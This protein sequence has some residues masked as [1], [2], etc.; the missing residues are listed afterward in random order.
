MSRLIATSA[1]LVFAALPAAA[2]TFI[3][4]AEFLAALDA[5]HFATIEAAEELALSRAVLDDAS[6]LEN[7][8]LEA[9]RE[10]PS[11]PVSQT[12]LMLSWRLPD[13]ARGREIEAATQRL[14]SARARYAQ[15]L[16][17]LRVE[18]RQVYAEWALASAREERLEAQLGR[19]ADLARRERARAEEGESSGLEA[20]RLA[21]AVDVLS[22]R[23]AIA[24]AEREA[25]QARARVWN[26]ATPADATPLLPELPAAPPAESAHPLLS[27]AQ[28]E[29]DAALA[30]REA[31]ARFL[32]SPELMGGWQR[33]EDSGEPLDGPLFGVN[34]SVPL[35]RRNQGERIVAEARVRSAEA[36]L[37]RLRR[38]IDA[39]RAASRARYGVLAG[40]V[41]TLERNLEETAR[42]LRGA[43]AAFLHGEASLTDFL[44][45][46]RS[47]TEAELAMLELREAALSS[48]R[49]AER[50]NGAT[51]SDHHP[52]KKETNQ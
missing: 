40:S 42:M 39:G 9:V 18:M 49:D 7:P 52:I 46:L 25:A 27:A 2:Q 1:L 8:S 51:E 17:S 3:T 33:Q 36:R 16:V 44:E 35:F 5:D 13:F 50:I 43:E 32:R 4:E 20:H 12:D 28:A 14:A 30:E 26:P 19:V 41:A 45:T 37:V 21:L 31:A 6:R 29:L 23:L 34:W 22:A 10:N 15:S 24:R 11:G 38:E 48:L 47:A